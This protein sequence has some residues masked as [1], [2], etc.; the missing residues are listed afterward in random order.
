MLSFDAARTSPLVIQSV[1]N[2][3]ATPSQ[4]GVPQTAAGNPQIANAAV[5]STTA[6]SVAWNNG[7]TWTNLTPESSVPESIFD[8]MA[9]FDPT[10]VA[11]YYSGLDCGTNGAAT[12]GVFFFQC[13]SISQDT[14]GWIFAFSPGTGS[15]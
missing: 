9:A 15:G 3:G 12:Q 7:M 5:A 4:P 14:P 2:P 11:S 6:Y 8:Q 13:D 1:F 10:F